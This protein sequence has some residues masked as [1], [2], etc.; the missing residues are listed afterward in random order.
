[1]FGEVCRFNC[2]ST[3]IQFENRF[4]VL[5]GF[6]DKQVPSVASVDSL[7]GLRKYVYCS[8]FMTS[9]DKLPVFGHMEMNEHIIQG[10]SQGLPYC[11]PC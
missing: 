5:Y 9:R 3:N 10:L 8:V 6:I 1:M 7:S 4:C 11:E 2:L